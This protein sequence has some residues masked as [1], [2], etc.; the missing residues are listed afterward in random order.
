MTTTLIEMTEDEFDASYPLISN[1][2]NPSAGWVLGEGTGCLFETFGEEL[3]FVRQQDPRC[4]WTLVDCDDGSMAVASG[5]HFVNRVGYLVS[6]IPSPEGA[7]AE[8]HLEMSD[9]EDR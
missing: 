2:M 8:V 1:H 6:T 9:A 5:M 4:V 3:A 7:L